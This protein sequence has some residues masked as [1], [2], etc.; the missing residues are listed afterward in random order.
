MKKLN[1]AEFCWWLLIGVLVIVIGKVLVFDELKFYL[2]PKMYKFVIG[3]EILLILLFIYQQSRI[4]K[5]SART[6]KPG[7]FLFLIPMFMLVMAGDASAV[8]F[9]N[10]DINLNSFSPANTNVNLGVQAKDL[11]PD[12][13]QAGNWGDYDLVEDSVYDRLPADQIDHPDPNAIDP[14][15][16][17]AQPILA[18]P[19]TDDPFLTTLFG[20]NED[21][22]GQ[23]VVLEGFVFKN[24]F[25]AGNQF[26][27]SR[28]NITC[29]VADAMLVGMVVETPSAGEF[30]N[31]DWVRVKGKTKFQMFKKP[32]EDK[33]E[34]ILVIEPTSIE[35]MDP[36]ESPYV[37]F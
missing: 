12:L 17:N 27:V 26:H 23:E 2:H 13:D 1:I 8:I 33:E 28:M 3:G 29:C 15:D 9:Q 18:W 31:N 30:N 4:F 7:Y 10:K 35:R 25:F 37:Y 6:F 11:N 20:L 16:P 19:Q 14:T 21:E 24:E 22:D 32:F 36:L 34:R 5:P